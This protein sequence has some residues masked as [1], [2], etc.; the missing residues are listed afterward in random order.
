MLRRATK[1]IMLALFV[2]ALAFPGFYVVTHKAGS[3]ASLLDLVKMNEK[4]AFL[5]SYPER[6]ALFNY[7]DATAHLGKYITYR[8][9]D[10]GYYSSAAFVSGTDPSLASLY[11]ERSVQGFKKTLSDMG[12]RYVHV[13]HYAH[14]AIYNTKMIDVLTS[15]NNSRLVFEDGGG[16]VYEINYSG[17]A[18]YDNVLSLDTGRP[19]QWTIVRDGSS[20]EYGARASMKND[21]GLLFL[22]QY[23]GDVISNPVASGGGQRIE[24]GGVY[25]FRAGVS[26]VGKVRAYLM[27]FPLQ[28]V[29][30][31]EVIKDDV[32]VQAMRPLGA[33]AGTDYVLIPVWNGPI[34]GHTSLLGAQFKAPFDAD[35]KLVFSLEGRGDVSFGSIRMERLSPPCDVG[36][37]F[38]P[39]VREALSFAAG[40]GYS[41]C[42]ELMAG[43]GSV[44]LDDS[45]AR[46]VYTGVGSV[47][48]SPDVY[49]GVLLPRLMEPSPGVVDRLKRVRFV[50]SGKGSVK[51]YLVEYNNIGI[52]PQYTLLSNL[53]LGAEPVAFERLVRLSGSGVEPR[54]AFGPGGGQW[55]SALQKRIAGWLGMFVWPESSGSATLNVSGVAVED[56]VGD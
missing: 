51:V 31:Q 12:I 42:T 55:S 53:A 23:G 35:Y 16:K 10:F 25:C 32:Y 6:R 48:M 7:V 8:Q 38:G 28:R 33:Q 26:G 17:A 30:A 44:R 29:Y 4:D 34:T 27:C 18:Q 36:R 14:P 47:L 3:K 20:Y 52:S 39:A 37:T 24:R 54:F 22:Y 40:S 2:L 43:G 49:R 13:P 50:A 1:I 46:L 41:D 15:F 56:V 9:S 45:A 5:A 21:D 11:G 19:G